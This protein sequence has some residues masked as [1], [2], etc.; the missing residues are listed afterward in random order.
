MGGPRRHGSSSKVTPE[1]SRGRK[2]VK[3]RWVDRARPGGKV[4]SRFVA[5]ELAFDL[6]NDTFAGTPPMTCVRFIVSEAAIQELAK[7]ILVTGVGQWLRSPR[8]GTT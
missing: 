1:A 4:K 5:M 7:L 6:R 3:S 2:T 8:R